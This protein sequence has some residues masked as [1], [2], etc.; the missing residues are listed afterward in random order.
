MKREEKKEREIRP[1]GRGALAGMIMGVLVGIIMGAILV[2]PYCA[3]AFVGNQLE[4]WS[5][6]AERER[7][8]RERMW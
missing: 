4:Y 3:R 8:E 5:L 6:K 2:F 7:L 1:S